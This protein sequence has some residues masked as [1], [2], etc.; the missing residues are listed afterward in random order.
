MRRNVS[1]LAGKEYDLVIVGGGIFG[2]CAAW[3]AAQRGLSVAL[4]ER[5]DFSHAT[6]ANHFKIVHGGIRYLQH[7]DLYRIR[8]SSRERSAL[9]RIAPHLVQPLQIVV[10]TYGH[11]LQGKGILKAG[12]ALYD[13]LVFDRNWGLR[14]PQ[15]QIPR[16]RFI[17]REECL[18]LFP[19]LE[20]KGLTGAAVFC[21]GQIYNPPRLALSFLQ[22]AVN[23]GAQV[24]NYVE[25]T[26]FLYSGNRV[27]GIKAKD[28]LTGQEIEIRGKVVLNAAGPWA[29]QLLDTHS[30]LR[31]RRG[32]TYSRDACFVVR[33]RLTGHLALSL[34]ASTNDP[35]AL[36]SR[37]RRHI[38]IA[39]WRN[40]TLIGVWH[41]VY[42][43]N[44][45]AFTVSEEELLGFL[46]EVNAG[47]PG[48]ELSL[49]DV[50]RWNAGIVLFG[51][52]KPGAAN[53]SFGKRSQLIDHMSVSNVQGL[54]TMI[55]VRATTAR[56]VAER[57]VDLVVKKL[58]RD[59]PKCRTAVTP[60]YGGRIEYFEDFI[61]RIVQ[62]RPS[63]VSQEAMRA[64]GRNYGSEYQE[65]L[66]LLGEDPTLAEIV[67]RST[68]LKAEVVHAVREEMACKLADVVFRR[69]DLATGEYPGDQAMG[70]CAELLASELEWSEE[71]IQSE[72]K[73]VKASFPEHVFVSERS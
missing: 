71:R 4:V 60:I 12:L 24:A 46:D 35:D 55:G 15:Q 61:N 62:E 54:I 27:L 16:A 43:G 44:P 18:R 25:A 65:P 50:S 56:G 40:Y 53:L 39:P 73:E 69:T 63:R 70:L 45:S 29:E 8:E 5:A 2:A 1:A 28:S 26:G 72:L 11:G 6:S 13:L 14:D 32:F 31:L 22:S 21:D 49:K 19:G 41:K 17:C 48:F 64:L 68:V 7:G 57:A 20:E 59:V 23:A 37:G 10:P 3:D 51:G 30:S 38:F 58:G 52:N 47:Y 67:G 33:R 66:K 34:P 36:L 9:L 42:R